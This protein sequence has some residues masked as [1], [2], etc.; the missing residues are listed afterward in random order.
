MAAFP[1]SFVLLF[2][3]LQ[4]AQVAAGDPAKLPNMASVTNYDSYPACCP[5]SPNYSPSA[6]TDECE[7]YSGCD[8][9]GDFAAYITDTNPSGHKSFEYVQ[10]HNMVAFYD[11]RDPKG[12]QFASRYALK[13]IRITHLVNASSL[14]VFDAII[15]DTCA[16]TDCDGCC[17]RNARPSGYLIDVEYYTAMRNFGSIDVAS[18]E[19]KFEIL[20]D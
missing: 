4:L 18:G 13:T 16:D 8:Y 1:F 5:S 12:E 10:S 20:E 11:S 15:A 3:W 9:I 19:A 14:V 6:A 7:N 2:V 17:T